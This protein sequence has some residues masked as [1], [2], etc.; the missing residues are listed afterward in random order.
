[1]SFHLTHKQ[2]LEFRFWCEE[3]A[4]DGYAAEHRKLG[5]YLKA[6]GIG[7]PNGSVAIR[8]L[9]EA[10][11]SSILEIGTGPHWGTLPYLPA[12]RR[13][14]IDPLIDTF[15]AAG[16]LTERGDIQYYSDAFEAWETNEQFDVIITTNAIDHGEMGFFCLLKMWRMLKPGG[17]IYLHVHLRPADLLNLLHDHSLTMEQFDKHL[18]YTDLEERERHILPNDVDGQF[19]ETLVWIGRKPK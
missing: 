1:M 11:N 19:C 2:L 18:S 9:L 5:L 4:R 14:A 3:K 17:M 12:R 8:E 7:Y 10:K 15:H 13:V 6:F 16:I